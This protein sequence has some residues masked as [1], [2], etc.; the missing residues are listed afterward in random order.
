MLQYVFGYNN[1]RADALSRFQI[2]KFQRLTPEAEAQPTP[3]HK[4]IWDVFYKGGMT[5]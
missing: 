5:I 2:E 4:G 1:P 3:V